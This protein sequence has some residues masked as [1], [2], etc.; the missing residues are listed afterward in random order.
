MESD[1]KTQFIRIQ[2]KIKW[3]ICFFLEFF[4]FRREKDALR[5][6]FAGGGCAAVVASLTLGNVRFAAETRT[7]KITRGRFVPR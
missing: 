4:F 6:R 7:A 3:F 5:P 1:S 2:R